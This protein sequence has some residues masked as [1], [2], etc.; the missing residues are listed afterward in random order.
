MSLSMQWYE[1]MLRN[2]GLC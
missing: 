1:E 2:I